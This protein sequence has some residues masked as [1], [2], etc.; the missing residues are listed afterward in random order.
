[1]RIGLIGGSFDP[2][3]KAHIE[4]GKQ[5]LKQDGCDEVWFIPS[6][7][8]PLKDRSLTAFEL[9]AEMVQAAIRPYSRM[10]LCTIERQLSAPSYTIKT[11][12][13][14][15]KQ[16]PNVQFVWYI[17]AD[18][19][20]QLDRWK[21]IDE[22]MKLAEFKVFRRNQ[23]TIDCPFELSVIDMALMPI[24][25]TQVRNGDFSLCCDSVRTLIAKH[26]LYLDSFVAHSMSE[27]RYLHSK[28]VAALAMEIA[29]AHGLD[30]EAAYTAGMLHDVCKQWPYERSL[31]W[32][33]QLYPQF[34]NEAPAIW[35]GYLGAAYVRRFYRLRDRQILNAIAHHVKGDSADPL[36]RII[37]MADKLDPL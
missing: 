17:G 20:A 14:L 35:H 32:M 22:C 27:K 8:T 28:S 12:Q 25:S 9:R 2:I 3:H 23:E 30:E 1:M 11:L 4:M 36:A 24:S 15:K 34:L 16:N 37:L 5:V 13:A 29:H 26:H 19:A 33:R 7:V 21:A 18:Q 6:V 31:I 10:R